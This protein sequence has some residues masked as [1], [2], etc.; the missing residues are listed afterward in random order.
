MLTNPLDKQELTFGG[1]FIRDAVAGAR[2]NFVS[3]ADREHAS[4]VRTT[5][6]D[7]EGTLQHWLYNLF[8]ARKAE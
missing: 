7:G 4:I 8:A 2:Q 5:G 1:R 6:L 3:F